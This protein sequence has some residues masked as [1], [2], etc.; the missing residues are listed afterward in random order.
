[1]ISF[2]NSYTIEHIHKNNYDIVKKTKNKPYRT[3]FLIGKFTLAGEPIKNP[4]EVGGL[5]F[6]IILAT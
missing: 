1:L 6:I 2:N 5:S 4:I 3:H